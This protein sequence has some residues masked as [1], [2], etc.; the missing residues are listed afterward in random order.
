MSSILGVILYVVIFPYMIL[1]LFNSFF[2]ERLFACLHLRPVPVLTKSETDANQP[3]MPN[4]DSKLV[5]N[6]D[7]V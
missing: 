4:S 3:N 5:E 2:R 6:G 7:S 1:A